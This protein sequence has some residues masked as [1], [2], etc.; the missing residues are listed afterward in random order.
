MPSMSEWRDKSSLTNGR[1][2]TT[3]LRDDLRVSATQ[4]SRHARNQVRERAWSY[5]TSNAGGGDS[6]IR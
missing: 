5:G 1:G 3:A 6:L 4:Q 2:E